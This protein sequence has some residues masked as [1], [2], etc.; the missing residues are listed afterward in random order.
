MFEKE[1]YMLPMNNFL[2]RNKPLLE[3]FYQSM[4]KDVTVDTTRKQFDENS[5][6]KGDVLEAFEPIFQFVEVLC[7]HYFL[8]P[9][10]ITF[11]TVNH[12]SRTSST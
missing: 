10:E 12:Q 2:E 9:I 1:L 6:P 7:S 3:A 4:L 11:L 5:F 8:L